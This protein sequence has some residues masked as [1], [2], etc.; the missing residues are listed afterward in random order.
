[1]YSGKRKDWNPVHAD[2]A[3]HEQELN[4]TNM[5]EVLYWGEEKVQ[6]RAVTTIEFCCKHRVL[7]V[8]LSWWHRV[9]AP[10]TGPP[11]SAQIK[12]SV[13]NFNIINAASCRT[14]NCEWWWQG[15]AL[16][17][18]QVRF[19][20]VLTHSTKLHCFSFHFLTLAVVLCMHSRCVSPTRLVY[21]IISTI[22]K[23]VKVT[24][25]ILRLF[26][27]NYCH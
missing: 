13:M 16:L 21:S 2:M 25:L 19:L 10:P 3:T 8:G 24:V 1:M 17:Q 27:S 26:K 22:E 15:P 23:G 7:P 4:W 18:G 9:K 5:E 12:V 6:G 11:I 20:F 14:M